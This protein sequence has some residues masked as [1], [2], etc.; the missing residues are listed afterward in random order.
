MPTFWIEPRPECEFD[1]AFA[2]LPMVAFDIYTEREAVV[3]L[4]FVRRWRGGRVTFNSF[5]M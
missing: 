2:W 3:W 4:R 5:A 1:D